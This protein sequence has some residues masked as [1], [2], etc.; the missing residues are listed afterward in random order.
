MFHNFNIQFINLYQYKIN[1]FFITSAQ[2]LRSS[3]PSKLGILPRTGKELPQRK[4]LRDSLCPLQSLYST[5]ATRDLL[6]KMRE[7]VLKGQ[8][9]GLHDVDFFILSP[10]RACRHHEDIVGKKRESRNP[11]PDFKRYSESHESR[12]ILNIRKKTPHKF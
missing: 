1:V 11:I 5:C 2:P 7:K 10:K 6:H 12:K 9:A 8:S 3:D 4:Q